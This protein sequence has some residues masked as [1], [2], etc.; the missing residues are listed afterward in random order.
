MQ[1]KWAEM[2]MAGVKG[3]DGHEADRW[4]ALEVHNSMVQA[5]SDKPGKK[6]KT[7]NHV[8]DVSQLPRI[9]QVSDLAYLAG[10]ARFS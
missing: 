3:R 4:K 5:I 1:S 2:M 9:T 6:R 10:A 7:R 8:A